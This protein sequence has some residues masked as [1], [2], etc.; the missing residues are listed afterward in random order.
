MKKII[1][2]ILIVLSIFSLTGC[3][4]T[5]VTRVTRMQELNVDYIQ[6]NSSGSNYFTVILS[7]KDKNIFIETEFSTKCRINISEIINK[8][9]NTPVTVVS[10]TTENGQTT[11]ENTVR[12]GYLKRLF[13]SNQQVV[14]QYKTITK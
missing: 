9:V 4:N 11:N 13:C 5:T 2:S 7:N 10:M 3:D 6:M 1:L 14:K 8:K 12:Q